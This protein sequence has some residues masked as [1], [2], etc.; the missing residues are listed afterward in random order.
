MIAAMLP[1]CVPNLFFALASSKSDSRGK[2]AVPTS[3]C[4]PARS[5]R[6]GSDSKSSNRAPSI[7]SALLSSAKLHLLSLAVSPGHPARV[8]T[9]FKEVQ[10]LQSK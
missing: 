5:S 3:T 2:V 6:G 9:Q 8:C 1:Y 7:Q 10:M 4:R